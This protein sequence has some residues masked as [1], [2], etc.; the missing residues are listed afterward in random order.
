MNGKWAP[1][2]ELDLSDFQDTVTA[3]LASTFL[4]VRHAVPVMR[5]AGHGGAI[6]ITS[7]INGTRV[8]S[9]PGT[10]LYSMTKAAQVALM[11]TWACELGEEGIRINAVCPGAF[12]TEIWDN[13]EKVRTEDARFPIEFP[14]GKIPRTGHKPGHP[15]EVARLVAFLASS[16]ASHISGSEMW[17]DGAESLTH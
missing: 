7:S 17:I 13:T 2:E 6:I 14:H 15:S 12:D 4:T 5:H 3:N 16:D 1:L 11:K 10:A 9:N 8:F